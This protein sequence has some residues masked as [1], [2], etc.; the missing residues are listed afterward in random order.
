MLVKHGIVAVWQSG[1]WVTAVAC[2]ST[3]F[4]SET[5]GGLA[6]SPFAPLGETLD[7]GSG[8]GGNRSSRGHW[9]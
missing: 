4:H 5:A 7:L 1:R 9:A 6:S 3:A 8:G 2:T